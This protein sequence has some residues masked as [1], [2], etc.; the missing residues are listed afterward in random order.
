ML[1]SIFVR[2]KNGL[3]YT[4][5]LSAMIIAGCTMPEQQGQPTSGPKDNI[6]AEINRYQA[7]IDAAHDQSVNP[8]P[9]LDSIRAYIA[10]EPYATDDAARQKNLDETWQLLTHLSPQ[11]MNELVINANEYTLQGWLDLLST[12]QTNKQDLEKLRSAVHD[13]QIRYSDNPAAHRLPSSLQQILLQETKDHPAIIGL[14]LPLDGQAKVFGN[15]IRQ[16]FLDAQKGL[17]EPVSP[18]N[19]NAANSENLDAVTTIPAPEATDTASTVDQTVKVYDTSSQPLTTLLAQA[20]QEGVT[21]VVGPLL[22]PNVEQLA[23]I[24]TPLNILALNEPDVPQPRPNICYFSLSPEDE[25]KNAAKHLWQQQKQT[26]LV[27]IP[28]T[29]LG[30]R[31]AKAFAEEWQILG[32]QTVRQQSFGTLSEMRQSMNRG[33]G[34]RLSGTPMISPRSTTTSVNALDPVDAVYIVAN[35]D[36]LSLIKPMIDMAISSRQKPALYANSRSNTSGSGPDFRLEMDGMQF[37]DIP[38]LTG[39][40]PPLIQQAAKKFTN[41]YS[42][43]RLYAMGIDAWS[44]ANQF[45]HLRQAGFNLKG[46]SG[47]LSV[48]DNCTILRQLPWM[49]FNQGR[50]VLEDRTDEVNTPD[51]VHSPEDTS[52][53]TQ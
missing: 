17:P 3:A 27:L 53:Q 33:I 50:I 51:D 22:K 26:P 52:S 15:A 41:D 6:S 40:N 5:L 8:P 20:Q 43:M 32:G 30:H 2:F 13:W 18:E 4:A 45:P 48:T 36:E 21:L 10:L 11:Q 35:A 44:L 47:E 16:G 49:R 37:S 39:T 7:I 1:P 14:F 9:L 23:Q 24:E 29:E 34:I 46:A 38:L 12:Y 28:P 42:L 19:A 31:I 25:A